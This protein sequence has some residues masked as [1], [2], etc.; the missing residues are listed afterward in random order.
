MPEM[1]ILGWFHTVLGIGAVLTGLYAIAKFKIISLENKIKA[2][3]NIISFYLYET[4]FR[5]STIQ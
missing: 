4:S 1:T 2:L 5:S 3:E